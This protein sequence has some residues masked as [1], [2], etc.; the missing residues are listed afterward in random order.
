MAMVFQNYALYPNMTVYEN[1]AFGLRMQLKGAWF[2]D[3]RRQEK[4]Q[5]DAKVRSTAEMLGISDLLGRYPR[6]LSGGQC[7]RVALGRCL[8]RKPTVFLFDEPLSNLDA[9]LRAQMRVELRRLHQ[10]LKATMLYVT[11]DQA[12]AMTLGDRMTVL[13]E[14]RICQ[15]GTPQDV[16]E[17]PSTEFVASFVG[18]PPM[19]LLPGENSGEWMGV[20][21]E[22][23]IPG[24]HD[25]EGV[26]DVLEPM[27]AETYLHLETE[28]GRVI[29][30][31][32][33]SFLCRQGE[34]L[35]FAIRRSVRIPRD[36]S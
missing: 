4:A 21:A 32:P 5:I 9:K 22:D 14:G 25:L 3:A 19:N 30:R 11:H 27:G 24:G 13:N 36:A 2:S 15:V 31:V 17:N 23:L 16:Y 1:M 26:V 34:K 18:N 8:V 29:A 12:E 6:E 20:R 28:K 7:Q 35:S 33:S 10:Q